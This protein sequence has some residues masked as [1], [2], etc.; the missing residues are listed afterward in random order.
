VRASVIAAS[1]VGILLLAGSSGQAQVAATSSSQF[2]PLPSLGFI[3]PYE[4]AR[5]V[6]RSGFDPLA[7][8]LREGSTYVVR[9]TDFRGIL[10]RVVVDARSGAIRDVN[11]IVPGPGSYGQT[12]GM[13][14]Y[15]E[16]PDDLPRP[17]GQPADY[18]LPPAPL[19]NGQGLGQGSGQIPAA[20]RPSAAHP[21]THASV[22]ILPPLPRPRPPELASRT[23][24]DDTKPGAAKPT[25]VSDSKSDRPAAD[26]KSSAK[27]ADKPQEKLDVTGSAPVA[28]SAVATT[29]AAAAA[30]PATA[31]AKPA[32][33][34]AP[35]PIND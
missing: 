20:P 23:P 16:E 27:A 17:Y 14:P 22:T 21:L 13:V 25:A 29:P 26:A 11:R 33:S 12:A 5:T 10:M 32:K 34:L 3:P 8:P 19:E 1:A 18:D 28:A 24:S 15:G 2:A 4:I 35:P 7:P 9:A 6:R 31:A 30:P